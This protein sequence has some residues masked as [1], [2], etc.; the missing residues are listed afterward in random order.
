MGLSTYW[1]KKGNVLSFESYRHSLF[2]TRE[3]IKK[4]QEM[5]GALKGQTIVDSLI[6]DFYLLW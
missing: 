5:S 1:G 3:N 2:K 6:N 4:I